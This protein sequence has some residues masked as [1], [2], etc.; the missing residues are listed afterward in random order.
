MDILFFE[1]F[2]QRG[3]MMRFIFFLLSLFSVP[4]YATEDGKALY[5]AMRIENEKVKGQEPRAISA[6]EIFR[7]T[8]L[9]FN[10]YQVPPEKN[11]QAELDSI[12]YSTANLSQ[13]LKKIDPTAQFSHFYTLQSDRIRS[14]QDR[15]SKKVDEYVLLTH[16][17]SH[18]STEKN[19]KALQGL[20]VALDPGHMGGDIWDERTGKYVK[21]GNIKLS[22][23]LMALQ[24]SLLIEKKLK[25]MGAEVLITH[26]ELGPASKI[27]YEK[28][29][30]KSFAKQELRYQ[31]LQPWFQTLIANTEDSQLSSQFNNSSAVK[32]I[33]SEIMRSDYYMLREDLAAREDLIRQFKP[34]I[35]V[36][37]H[38]DSATSTPQT[39]VSNQTMAYVTGNFPDT[40]FSTGHNRAKILSHLSQEKL[41]QESVDLSQTLVSQIS[42]D[43]QVKVATYGYLGI[44]V[45]PGVFARNLVLSR[46]NNYSPTA[47]LECL[48]YGNM[49]EFDR[50][51][52]TDGGSLLIGGKSYAYSS[53]IGQLANAITTGIIK[54]SDESK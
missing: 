19:V 51:A 23:A 21:K 7:K 28:L 26:R 38:F 49:A 9:I 36:I 45:A 34:D 6:S 48:Y 32:K 27:P 54:Y 2:I 3:K 22:E 46:E 5:E 44:G 10:Y 24:T 18:L 13:F 47:Y 25:S 29:D 1:H 8:Q 35:T 33:F 15:D 42:Q 43:L 4:V 12:H 31:S 41:W 30:L 16:T 53:R 37:I 20:R 50:L 52:K 11:E 14:Y 39:N 17:R 40:D